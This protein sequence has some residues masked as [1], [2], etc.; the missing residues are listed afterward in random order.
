MESRRRQS[1]PYGLGIRPPLQEWATVAVDDLITFTGAF[2]AGSQRAFDLNRRSLL[3]EKSAGSSLAL[4][5]FKR[6][7]ARSKHDASVVGVPSGWR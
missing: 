5:S 2:Q 6:V 4:R 1:R 3:G 7:T